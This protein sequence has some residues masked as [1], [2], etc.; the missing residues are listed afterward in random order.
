[1][2]LDKGTIEELVVLPGKPAA[3]GARSTESTKVD[4]LVTT[5]AKKR[6]ELAEEDLHS[7]VDEL[8]A[9]QELLW[10]NGT[11]ALLVVLQAMDAAGK[12]GTITHVMSG[13]NPQGCEV[14]AFKQPSSEELGHDFLWRAAKALPGRGR[15]GIFNR[16]Y[17][18]EVL[19]VR[20]HPEL[21][22]R[23]GPVPGKAP[24]NN[25]WKDRYE[26]INA[27]ELHLHRNGTRVVK[28]FLH[29]SKEEQKRR[30]LERLD[31][32]AKYWKFSAADLA[33]RRHWDDYMAAYE[34]ALTATSTPWAPWYVV[35]ADHKYTLR[36]LVGGI[37]VH[38]I[39][40]MDLP[41]PK[42]APDGLEALARAKAQLLAE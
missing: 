2:R 40:E 21:L 9:S 28:I 32:P 38:T 25:V 12:D 33:E 4:W 29:V 22:A 30:F 20:V 41:S 15:I 36:A 17:Y 13:V 6:K 39:D 8:E 14:T 42:V 19:V 11:H 24:A 5:K 34:Q 26:D 7:F 35:P 27:F 37:V 10:A 18:E 3:L 23:G 31:D 1:M 16:S